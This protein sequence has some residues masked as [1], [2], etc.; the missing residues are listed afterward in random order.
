MNGVNS[1]EP[2]ENLEIRDVKGLEEYLYVTSDGDVYSKD[3]FY[4]NKNGKKIIIKGKLKTP[5][6][7]NCGYYQ[8]RVTV[9]GRVHRKYLHRILAE[10]FIPNPSNYPEVNHI[11]GNK[12]NNSIDNLEWCS[13]SQ[14]IQHA[15]SNN[16]IT[17]DRNGKFSKVI[18]S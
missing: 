15:L 4:I 17:R 14:N 10:A 11:D 7:N 12:E 6:N 16:L 8:I 2:K 9:N 3:R 13:K 1:V 5:T 18:L